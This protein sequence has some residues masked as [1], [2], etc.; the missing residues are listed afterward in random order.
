MPPTWASVSHCVEYCNVR[1]TRSSLATSMNSGLI[2]LVRKLKRQPFSSPVGD[3]TGG[4]RRGF[5]TLPPGRS[6]GRLRQNERPSFT[7]ATPSS[8]FLGVI[9]FRR[10]N[11]SS[12]PQSPQV[13]PSGRCFQRFIRVSPSM[14]RETTSAWLP[15]ATQQPRNS[16]GV[17]SA[18]RL[19]SAPYDEHDRRTSP[20]R[21]PCDQPDRR[22][23]RIE[24]LLPARVHHDAADRARDHGA[25]LW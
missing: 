11:W 13:E 10:P 19:Y 24:P 4:R 5:N 7:S 20:P 18:D 9:R 15:F 14:R 25:F 16:N 17:R 12:S 8:T 2:D 6:S 3:S 21:L 22:R 1:I 23:A